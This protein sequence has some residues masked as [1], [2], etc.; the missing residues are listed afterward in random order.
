MPSTRRIVEMSEP[1]LAVDDLRVRFATPDGEVSA[2]S[3]I[4]FA[5]GKGEALGVVGE[6]G[7]GKS[8]LFLAVMGL[9]AAN[10]RAEGRVR[11]RG[12]DLLGL[13]P[14]ALNAIRG[15]RIAMVFQDPM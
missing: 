8:Q 15:S 9:L 2:V 3:G 14:N 11:Y 13:A 4:S 6:S 7:S 10:G 5:I 1:I 12:N